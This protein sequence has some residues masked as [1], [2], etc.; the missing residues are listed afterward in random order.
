MTVPP[1]DSRPEMAGGINAGGKEIAP[2]RVSSGQKL[3]IAG[4]CLEGVTHVNFTVARHEVDPAVTGV[5]PDLIGIDFG[6]AGKPRSAP[7][8]LDTLAAN[9]G[10]SYGARPSVAGECNP[11]NLSGYAA[12]KHTADREME[13]CVPPLALSGPIGFWRAEGKS[14]DACETS[15]VARG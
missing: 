2:Q 3:R 14:G 11:N 9:I 8:G 15:D 7:R 4:R 13:V 12:V 5:N 1:F 10:R 6:A